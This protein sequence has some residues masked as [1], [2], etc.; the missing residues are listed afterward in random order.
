MPKTIDNSELSA[1]M[2]SWVRWLAQDS[3]GSWWAYEAE[4]L[5]HDSGWYENEV[6]RRIRFGR[7]AVMGDW[8][9]SLR[10]YSTG[11]PNKP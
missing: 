9:G 1:E 6:G 10:R 5:Q 8:K 2:P 4:P 7:S 11:E 3:D